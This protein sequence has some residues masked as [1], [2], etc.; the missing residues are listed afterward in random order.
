MLKAYA[1]I[2]VSGKSQLD[3]DGPER[4]R[5]A[6]QHYARQN[7]MR[8]VHEYVEAISGSKESEDRPKWTEM[9]AAILANGVGTVVVESLGR[10]ELFVHR[11][12]A[13]CAEGVLCPD[14]LQT[15][16]KIAGRSLP[17][18]QRVRFL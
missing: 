8:I 2:R 13:E 7:G 5:I 17:L 12:K 18:L 4:Q 16:E 15:V 11:D 14:M 1:Y 3:G 10:R 6:T 9:V